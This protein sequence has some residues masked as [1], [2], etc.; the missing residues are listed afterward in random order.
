MMT[1]SKGSL[2]AIGVSDEGLHVMNAIVYRI[3]A[4][5]WRVVTCHGT[6][7][8][9]IMNALR[10]LKGSPGPDTV[11]SACFIPERSV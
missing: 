2:E 6:W 10:V 8:G 7:T 5:T 3:N 1:L 4:T 9:G 11:R